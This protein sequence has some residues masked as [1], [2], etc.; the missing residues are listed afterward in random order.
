M[1]FQKGIDTVNHHIP[2]KNLIMESEE[3]PRTGLP[4]I[5]KRKRFVSIENCDSNLADVKCRVHQDSLL[6]PI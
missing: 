2:L 4:L 3:F 5:S 6:R 1:D